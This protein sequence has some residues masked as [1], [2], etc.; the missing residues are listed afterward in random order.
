MRRL[1]NNETLNKATSKKATKKLID[2]GK[3]RLGK[4]LH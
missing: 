1:W 3:M 2:R 4:T